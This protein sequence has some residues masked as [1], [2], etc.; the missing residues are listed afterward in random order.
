MRDLFESSHRKSS[1]NFYIVNIV[2]YIVNIV[3]Y[4]VKV[5]FID[6]FEYS[7]GLLEKS[8]D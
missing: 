3:I 6:V 2:I 1:G 4:I 5:T 8:I 7:T